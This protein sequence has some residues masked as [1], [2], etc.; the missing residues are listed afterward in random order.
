MVQNNNLK[1]HLL[2]S[3]SWYNIVSQLC[4]IKNKGVPIVAQRVKE[5][6]I[7]FMTTQV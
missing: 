1:N 4:L 2:C 3:G 6:D 5:P 7:V